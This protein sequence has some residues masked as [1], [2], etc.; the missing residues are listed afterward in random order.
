MEKNTQKTT[1]KKQ[2]YYERNRE[3]YIETGRQYYEEN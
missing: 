1:K 2:R 3:K